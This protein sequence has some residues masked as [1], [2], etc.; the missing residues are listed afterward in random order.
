MDPAK[1]GCRLTGE[2]DG[3]TMFREYTQARCRFECLVRVSSEKCRQ[4]RVHWKLSGLRG[5]LDYLNLS[6]SSNLS[7]FRCFPWN[8]P[9]FNGNSNDLTLCDR[10]GL[11]CF[12]ESMTS[13]STSTQGGCD[14]PKDCSE[15]SFDS[16]TI[17]DMPIDVDKE[18]LST[19]L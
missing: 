15:V 4:V 9:N 14:C 2:A 18:C 6:R 11:H 5:A 12:E 19:K 13:S 3:L 1:R 7:C 16:Y 17:Q 8:Y 10:Y